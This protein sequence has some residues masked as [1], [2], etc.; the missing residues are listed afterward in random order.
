VKN[1]IVIGA[2]SGIGHALAII[3][4]TDGYRI[5]LVARRTDLL[6]QLGAK[7]PGTFRE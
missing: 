5:G 6:A 1:A 7:L 3:L 4:S 2:S